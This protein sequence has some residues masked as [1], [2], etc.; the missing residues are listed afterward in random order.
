MPKIENLNYIFFNKIILI[1]YQSDT[2][3][4]VTDSQH[5]KFQLSDRDILNHFFGLKTRLEILMIVV[6]T[7]ILLLGSYI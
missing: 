7:G 1:K 5:E 2:L 4:T 3:I 6:V